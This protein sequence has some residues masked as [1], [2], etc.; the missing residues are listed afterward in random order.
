MRYSKTAG[1]FRLRQRSSNDKAMVE[2]LERN[3]GAKTMSQVKVSAL[4]VS[5]DGFGAG[6]GQDLKNPL[7]IRGTELH[8]WMLKT[9]MFQKMFRKG[10]GTTDVDNDFAEK[11][12]ENIGAWIMGRN[13]FAPIRG[14]WQDESWKGWWGDNPPYHCP[15]Y[16]LTHYARPPL[17]MQGGTT[18]YFIT[19]GI[20]SA[21]K[22]ARDA[23]QGRDI[24][25]GGGASVIRQYLKARLVDEMHLAIS[26]V[27]LG[28]GENLFSG[29]NLPD[30][31]FVCS[32]HVAGA[33]ALHVTLKKVK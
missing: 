21:L 18:F 13:M 1:W 25:I 17:K 29:I 26:P 12:M 28:A 22:Q 30:L 20:E 23:A 3:A 7:G 33:D 16:V 9:R 8:Q 27:L 5:L 24:R 31:G 15:V 14:A 11:S 2:D 4:T 32:E 10:G 6:P 19:D